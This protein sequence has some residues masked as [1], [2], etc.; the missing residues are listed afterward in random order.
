M[1][2]KTQATV[3]AIAHHIRQVMTTAS[4]AFISSIDAFMN[5]QK[6][7]VGFNSAPTWMAGFGPTEETMKYPLAVNGQLTGAQ[8]MIVRFPNERGVKFRLGILAPAMVSRLD[9]TNE[10]H[11]NSL[12]SVKAKVLP[13]FVTGPHYH[14]WKLNRQFFKSAG[15]PPK[16]HDA[17][18]LKIAALSFDAVLRWYCSDVN[19]LPLPPSH[20]IDLSGIGKLI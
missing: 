1:V 20:A 8:L 11:G 15:A 14:S 13:A 16:L 7:I 4:A 6:S 9:F 3:W 19:I 5:A 10:T 17:E 2:R 12:V 18:E